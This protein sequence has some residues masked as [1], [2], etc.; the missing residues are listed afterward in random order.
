M[1]EKEKKEKKS[2]ILILW[3]LYISDVEWQK[4]Q[5]QE[6]FKK[7]DTK[8]VSIALKDFQE[9]ERKNEKLKK[10]FQNQKWLQKLDTKHVPHAS[11]KDF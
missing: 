6:G 8:H 5:N 7:L 9:K 11:K 4:Y 10:L 2:R 3:S 1:S